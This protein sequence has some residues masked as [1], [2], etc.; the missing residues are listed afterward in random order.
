MFF[1]SMTNDHYVIFQPKAIVFVKSI[2]R[3]NFCMGQISNIIRARNRSMYITQTKQSDVISF[4]AGGHCEVL[5]DKDF[6]HL[7][8]PPGEENK[9]V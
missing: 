4:A 6:V 5:M 9:E 8:L 2:Y 7:D 1:C 3:Y